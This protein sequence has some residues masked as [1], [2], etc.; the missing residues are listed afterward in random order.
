M[1][2]PKWGSSIIIWKRCFEFFGLPL[3]SGMAQINYIIIPEIILEKFADG[4]E[5]GENEVYYF[6]YFIFCKEEIDT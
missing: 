1:N 3:I 2:L 6:V 5:V 4:F